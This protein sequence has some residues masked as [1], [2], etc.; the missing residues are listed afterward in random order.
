MPS[1]SLPSSREL[2]RVLQ[3]ELEVVVIRV[4]SESDFL[5]RNH[6]VLLRLDFFLLL[7]L[8]IQELLVFRDP[9]YRWIGLGR[10]LDQ[11]Q[12]HLTR[13]GQWPLEV[14]HHCKAPR[15]LLPMRTVRCRDLVID[16]VKFLLAY[17]SPVRGLFSA[18]S[19]NAWYLMSIQSSFLSISAISERI[20]SAKASTVNPPISPSPCLRTETVPSAASLSPTMSM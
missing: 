1:A 15:C 11:V 2:P 16:P 9:A 14:C 17:P 6:F 19:Y 3:L 18:N 12:F 4:R 20:R 13:Q 10:N 8:V 7:L 5:H